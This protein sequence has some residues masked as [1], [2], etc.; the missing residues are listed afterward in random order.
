MSLVFGRKEFRRLALPLARTV[1]SGDVEIE[2]KRAANGEIDKKTCQ[3]SGNH[4][5]GKAG[6]EGTRFRTRWRSF[7]VVRKRDCLRRGDDD[8]KVTKEEKDYKDGF[9]YV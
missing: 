1:P 5:I 3:L 4:K 8:V 7:V 6:E 9:A 2:L